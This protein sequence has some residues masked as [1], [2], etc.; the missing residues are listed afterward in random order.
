[1]TALRAVG[2]IRVSTE[3]YGTLENQRLSIKEYCA[4]QGFA[5]IRD[6]SDEEQSGSTF[7]R[8][9]IQ[10]LFA[11][12]PQ[13]HYDVVVVNELTRFGRNT[14]ELLNN[15]HFLEKHNVEF[16]SVREQVVGQATASGMLMTQVLSAIS[17]FELNQI[18]QRTSDVR[19]RKWKA[20]EAFCGTPPYGYLYNPSTKKLE[21]HPEESKIYQR[22]V[23]MYLDRGMSLLS[24][25]KVLQEEHVPRRRKPS[26]WHNST[27]AQIL[28]LDTYYTGEYVANVNIYEKRNGRA[29][30]KI[31]AKKPPEEWIV[32]KADKLITKHRW[33]KIQQRLSENT[34]RSGRPGKNKDKFLLYG[35]CSCG[36]CGAKKLIVEHATPRI[37]GT[38]RR[39]YVC[40]W[41]E[42]SKEH[43]RLAGKAQCP[44]PPVDADALEELVYS[45]LLELL[46]LRAED[47]TDKAKERRKE[48]L[49]E[50]NTRM[51]NAKNE[52]VRLER[53][54]KRHKKVLLAFDEDDETDRLDIEEFKRDLQKLSRKIKDVD[55]EIAEIQLEIDTIQ[56]QERQEEEIRGF[57]LKHYQE[58]LRVQR[59]LRELP[60]KAKQRLVIGMLDGRVVVG[61]FPADDTILYRYEDDEEGILAKDAPYELRLEHA[62][63]FHFRI[64]LP[65]LEEVLQLCENSPLH[66]AVTRPSRSLERPSFHPLPF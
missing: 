64:N 2:Y 34:F 66:G 32:F 49:E 53:A 29:T 12:I 41:H 1:M 47:T 54:R 57:G 8:P 59:C 27:I 55:I 22:I 9:G 58:L 4:S 19:M 15:L 60:F 16:R 63:K 23:A 46:Y 65:I 51:L 3:D 17:E 11:D 48:K 14:K 40:T 45:K 24:I 37:D 6:Y 42:H 31:V 52:K 61:P 43:L 38:A 5:W 10:K 62:V 39:N 35:L 13:G 26:I 21:A 25:C 20:N 50:L 28:H 33:D 36:Y 44:F 7:D 30:S 18:K 56:E